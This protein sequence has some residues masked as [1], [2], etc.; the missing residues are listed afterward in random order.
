LVVAA[1]IQASFDE[2]DARTLASET[3]PTAASV[4]WL[5]KKAIRSRAKDPDTDVRGYIV[6]GL[7]RGW[8]PAPKRFDL[9]GRKAVAEKEARE[10]ALQRYSRFGE[11]RCRDCRAALFRVW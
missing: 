11:V 2:A 8:R 3:T 1:L 6:S 5:H 10:L 7:R 4:E 9:P